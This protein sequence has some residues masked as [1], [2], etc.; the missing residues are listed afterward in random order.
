MKGEAVLFV[1]R[2]HKR[3]GVASAEPYHNVRCDMDNWFTNSIWGRTTKDFTRRNKATDARECIGKRQKALNDFNSKIC[4]KNG[5]YLIEIYGRQSKW[6]VH[7]GDGKVDVLHTNA[8]I[9]H[10]SVHANNNAKSNGQGQM[11]RRRKPKSNST[12]QRGNI[13]LVTRGRS[14]MITTILTPSQRATT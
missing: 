14:T 7:F 10:H 6:T 9:T 8:F 4:P 11:R 13:S 3:P 2:K 12:F 5:K 1:L